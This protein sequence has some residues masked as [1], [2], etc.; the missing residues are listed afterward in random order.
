MSI[1]SEPVVLVADDHGL[2]LAANRNFETQFG[3]CVNEILGKSLVNLAPQFFDK[4]CFDYFKQLRTL[5]KDK[6]TGKTR[7]LMGVHACGRKFPVEL[8]V[9]RWEN[10]YHPIITMIITNMS[11]RVNMC[12]ELKEKTLRLEVIN[13]ELESFS[14]SVSHDLRAPLRSIDGFSQILL[15]KYLN[16]IDE[17]GQ[18]YLMKVRSGCQDMARLLDELIQLSKISRI[19]M[20]N[21][22]LNLGKISQQILGELFKTEPERKVEVKITEEL[23]VMGD[24]ELLKILMENLLQNAWKFTSKHSRALIEVGKGQKA[25]GNFFYY[26]RDD[27]AGFDMSYVNKLFKPFQRLHS[28]SEFSGSGIGLA[29]VRRIIQ[30]H[31]GEVWAEGAIEQGAIIYFKL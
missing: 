20:K 27:G 7:A 4:G 25:D 21:Q 2:I 9:V 12:N 18:R 10:D 28:A 23:D 11:E 31:G 30:R 24:P 8:S 26:V 29:T 5:S 6:L 1:E 19:P 15:E 16:K 13:N 3:Y 22:S 14:Y 17:K